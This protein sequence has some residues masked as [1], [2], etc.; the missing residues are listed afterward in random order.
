MKL[1]CEAEN[2]QNYTEVEMNELKAKF[3]CKEHTP[4]Q[5]QDI[6]LQEQQFDLRLEKRYYRTADGMQILTA[7]EEEIE[8]P[9][10]AKTDEGIRNIISTAFP[11]MNSSALQR[12]RAGRWAR[13]LYLYYKLRWSFSDIAEEMNVE[14][15]VVRNI[16]WRSVLVGQG[17]K[18]NGTGKRA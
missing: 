2:C 8:F 7:S 4:K 13:V 18:A 14:T 9:E 10:W 16:L 3:W 15:K 6:F 5:E 17:K 12:S 11:K 1:F